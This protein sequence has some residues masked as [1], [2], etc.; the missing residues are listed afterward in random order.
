MHD[1]KY[2]S[3]KSMWWTIIAIPQEWRPKS[4]WKTL[5]D[6]TDSSNENGD[7]EWIVEIKGVHALHHHRHELRGSMQL[8]M[9]VFYHL[10]GGGNWKRT[11]DYCTHMQMKCLHKYWHN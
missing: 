4:I 10:S 6:A 7:D 11:E 5:K 3:C 9:N 2:V 8:Y 1:V